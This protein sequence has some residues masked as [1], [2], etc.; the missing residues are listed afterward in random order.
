MCSLFL[1]VKLA[2]F[3]CSLRVFCVASGFLYALKGVCV[4]SKFSI[5]PA[6]N[7]NISNFKPLKVAGEHQRLP[8][9]PNSSL[10]TFQ[11]GLIPLITQ[12]P[13]ITAQLTPNYPPKIAFYYAKEGGKEP[14]LIFKA[15][16]LKLGR[17]VVHCTY[18]EEPKSL[19]GANQVNKP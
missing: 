7:F 4:A 17:K 14:Q 10:N 8:Q 12:L 11:F 3:L 2:G 5:Q 1:S 13:S 6:K 16:Q 9:Y 19:L 15:I 18:F